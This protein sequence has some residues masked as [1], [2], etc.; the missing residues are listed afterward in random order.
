MLRMSPFFCVDSIHI[1][2]GLGV[3]ASRVGKRGIGNFTGS[4]CILALD[5]PGSSITLF[6]VSI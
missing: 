2:M 4:G 5:L 1:M 3:W 6:R